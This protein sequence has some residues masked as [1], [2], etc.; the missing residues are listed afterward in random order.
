MIEWA[1]S[2]TKPSSRRTRLQTAAVVVGFLAI[3]FAQML[4]LARANSATWDEPDHTY[5][6]YMQWKHGDFGL[7]PEHPPLVKFLTTLPL[8]GMT[9]KEPPLEDRVYRLQEAA[10]GEQFLF[11]NDANNFAPASRP[12]CSRCCWGC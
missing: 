11:E 7:N 9:L 3:I 12:R 6:G 4:L 5:A 10:G 1:G 2:M 8:L